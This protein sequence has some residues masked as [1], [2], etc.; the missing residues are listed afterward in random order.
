MRTSDFCR[1]AIGACTA[2]AMLAGCSGGSPLGS[3]PIQEN[4][5]ARQGGRSWMAPE[6]KKNDLLY[7]SDFYGNDVLVFSYPGG[8]PVGT[9]TGISEAQGVCTSNK[10]KGN[11]WVVATGAN[12]ILEFAHGGTTPIATLNVT[13]GQPAGCAVD[14]TTR[15]LAVTI[16]S[17]NEVVVYKKGSG[18]GTPYVTPIAPFFCGYDNQG[19][20]FVDGSGPVPL[21]E[22]PKG[23]SSFESITLDQTIEFSGGVAWDGTYLAIGDQETSNIYRF[24]ISGSSGTEVGATPL[25]GGDAGG[26]WIHKR[27]VIAPQTDA[28]GI[29]RYP[30]GGS[31][32]K[33]I[34]G[35]FEDPIGVTISVAK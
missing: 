28:V 7:V 33:L 5:A 4:A 35:G 19:D 3:A 12:E 9:L 30:A 22:L 34:T 24:A 2:V 13:A 6:A 11:W 15:S 23:G 29:W 8:A 20:L 17:S 32:T 14:P 18:P 10:S 26:F 27:N 31:P 16:L 1:F 21:V 25:D